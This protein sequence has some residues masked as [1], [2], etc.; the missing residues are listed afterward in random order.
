[1]RGHGNARDFFG[2]ERLGGDAGDHRTV[3]PAA[4]TQNGGLET[5]LPRVVAESD[6][7]GIVEVG[8]IVAGA[9]SAR[10]GNEGV[11]TAKTSPAAQDRS[12]R[13]HGEGVAVE[14]ELVITANGIAVVKRHAVLFRL[15]ADHFGA[16]RRLAD[17]ER[18][19][20]EVQDRLRPGGGERCHGVLRVEPARKV[21]RGPNVLAN[22]DTKER[23]AD[24]KRAGLSAGFEVAGFVEDIVGRQEAFPGEA[25]GL[26]FFQDGG[27]VEKFAPARVG[28]GEHAADD[29][30]GGTDTGV[31]FF[32]RA[33]ARGNEVR[34]EQEVLRRVAGEGEFGRKDNICAAGLKFARGP[35]DE[36]GVAFDVA[37]RGVDLREP[38]LHVTRSPTAASP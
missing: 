24:F 7:E 10:L 4:Q 11:F 14:D 35:G 30:S 1:M 23:A 3:D 15:A 25:G 33:Q 34:Y 29:P 22:R 9:R 17:L 20:A 5:A 28:V 18:R 8:D 27:G 2:T 6:D 12:I 38:D 19:G 31:D 21:F 16:Q 36:A 32:Q 13:A 26:S 37:D